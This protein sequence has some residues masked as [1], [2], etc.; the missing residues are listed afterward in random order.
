MEMYSGSCSLMGMVRVKSKKERV[1]EQRK[2]E[3]GDLGGW[4]LFLEVILQFTDV[5]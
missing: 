3:F 2:G 5:A 4:A 1:W